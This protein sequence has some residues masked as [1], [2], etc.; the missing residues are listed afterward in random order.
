[1]P[2]SL[3]IAGNYPKAACADKISGTPIVSVNV[4]KES[5][6]IP[7]S[8]ELLSKSGSATLDDK[9]ISMVQGM[10]YSAYGAESYIVKVG[11]EYDT[12]VCAS[13]PAPQESPKPEQSAKPEQSPKPQES[14][15]PQE[16]PKPQESAKPQ[17]SPKSEKSPEG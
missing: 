2:K 4:D 14:A 3:A 7:S 12:S 9:A 5:N 11:F 15:K 10:N 17:E 6:P 13:S 16:S 1:V 8:I